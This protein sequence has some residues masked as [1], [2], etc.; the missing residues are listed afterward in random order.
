MHLR[1][2]NLQQRRQEYTIEKI[3]SLQYWCWEIWIATCQRMKLECSLTPYTKINPKWIKDLNVRQDTIKLF[4]EKTGRTLFDINHSNIFLDTPPRIMK[5]KPKINRWN[6]MKLKSF[7]TAKKTINKKKRQSTEWEKIFA[8][9][10]TDKGLISEI[11]KQFLQVNI[12]KTH[13]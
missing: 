13:K 12:K 8:N 6:L 4:E 2:I 5:I 9:G 3:Q 11:Y 7:C 1:S 10:A